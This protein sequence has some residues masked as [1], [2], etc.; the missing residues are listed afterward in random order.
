M[1]LLKR[2][3]INL[4]LQNWPKGT[5][6]TSSWLNKQGIRFDLVAR[7]RKS[8]WV[9]PVGHGAFQLAGDKVSW[10]GALYSLQTQLGLSTH[11]AGKSALALL[12][13]AHY[14]PLGNREKIVLF[15]ARGERLPAWFRKRDWHA[16]IRHVASDLLPPSAAAGFT[17]AKEDGFD[18][19]ISSAER[20]ILEFL[21]D[22][23]L[24][25]SF[26][27][28]ELLFEGLMTLRP[29]VVGGLLRQC[30]SVKVKRLFMALAG[31][32][33]HPWV[34][35]LNLK[36]VDFGKGKRLLAPHGFLHPQ[37]QITLPESWKSKEDVV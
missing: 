16:E 19:T 23:P 34:S 29:D 36:Q 20:A 6:A 13:K 32:F 26:E 4:L 10:C 33:N 14:V 24:K 5:V 27:E 30:S 2:N 3:K 31:R 35:S 28:A 9:E 1:S 37:Y 17:K 22:V 21:H 25:G 15:S 7:Y 8:G 18:Y 12:G 11:V